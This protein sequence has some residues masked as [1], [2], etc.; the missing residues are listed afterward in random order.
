M[1]RPYNR[2]CP[3]CVKVGKVVMV[4]LIS[5]LAAPL[6]AAPANQL[7]IG[8]GAAGNIGSLPSGAT[9]AGLRGSFLFDAAIEHRLFDELSVALWGSGAFGGGDLYLTPSDRASESIH[10]FTTALL[11]ERNWDLDKVGTISAGMGGGLFFV[12]DQILHGDATLSSAGWAPLA[13]IHAVW[14][15]P[16]GRAAL[17]RIRLG[18]SEARTNL[19][20]EGNPG[21]RLKSDWSRLELTLG[22]GFGL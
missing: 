5:V 6:L 18:W 11:L 21:V 9:D 12:S 19:A 7:S 15:A 1:P 10:T 13:T 3:G 14:Q 8:I 16:L 17:Y 2:G 20:L 22:L 4:A